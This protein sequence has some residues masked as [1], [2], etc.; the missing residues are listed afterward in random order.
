MKDELSDK[1]PQ[2]LEKKLKASG[3]ELIKYRKAELI[4]KIRSLII[5][6]VYWSDDKPPITQK[7]SDY[8]SQKLGR[9]YHYLSGLF[10]EV[11]GVTIEKYFILQRTEHAKELIVYGELTLQSI[12]KKIHYRNIHHFSNQFK[13][14]TGLSP[15]AFKK[16]KE[17]SEEILI[18]YR[19]S[20]Q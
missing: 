17:K 2:T 6:I 20:F 16:L 1:Q 9:E 11:E 10:S 8:T 4:E 12:A 15:T 3:F 19:G 5:E 7:Y 18:K 13:S 14:I